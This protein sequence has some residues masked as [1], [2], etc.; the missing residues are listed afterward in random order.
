M[1]R[2]AAPASQPLVRDPRSPPS[3]DRG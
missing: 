3:L 2:G 1:V